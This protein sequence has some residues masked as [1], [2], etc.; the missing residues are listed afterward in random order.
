MI[1]TFWEGFGLQRTLTHVALAALTIG[2]IYAG[3]LYWQGAGLIYVGTIGF[4][5]LCVLFLCVT[6]LLGPLNLL[7][8]RINPVNIDLRR[9]T[10][11][12]AGITG[13]LHVVFAVIRDSRGNILSF[14][15]G[16]G[17]IALVNVRD[18]SNDLGLIAT[19]L[20]IVLMVLSN[21]LTLRK[22]K[23]KRWKT[24][25]RLNYV[26]VPLAIVH[27]LIYERLNGRE[28]PFIDVTAIV[29]LL[30]LIVQFIGVSTYQK[31]KA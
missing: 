27:T 31:R 7:R 22:L 17:G 29:I 20:L 25:Q 24:L 3:T 15:F 26:L 8:K 9:D 1:R 19:I 4:G 11:I 14:F 13:C 28:K 5:Y 30:V 12:W 23:G 16:G 21:Q 6:L 10:G 18:V 2:G